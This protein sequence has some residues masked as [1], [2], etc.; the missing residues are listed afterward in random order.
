MNPLRE[1][2]GNRR[3]VLAHDWLTGMRGG[4]RVLER[5]C[6][7]FPEAPLATLIADPAAVTPAIRNR[8]IITSTLQHIP[9][10]Q[11]HYRHF[12][13]LFPLAASS[14]RLPPADLVISTSHCVAKSFRAPPGARH[15]CYCFTPMRYAW[16][17]HD[18]YLG[19]TGIKRHAARPALAALRRWDYRTRNRVDHYIAISR[20]IRERI[21]RCYGCDSDV[22]YPPVN[23]SR[24]MPGDLPPDAGQYD[25][26]VSALVPYKR[27]DL[28]VRAYART[29]FPLRIV[30][31][32]T[33][34]ESLQA[35]A[36]PNV[37]FLGWRDDAELTALYRGCR[38]LIFP[39][40]E[41]FGI[42]PLEAQACGRPVVAFARGGACETVLDG[43]TGLFFH[44][45]TETALAAAVEQ[46]SGHAWQ[47][48]RIRQHAEA[49][50]EDR[51]DN[52]LADAVTSR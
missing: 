44:E 49:F 33:V 31:T 15:V 9:G 34:A 45:Q 50:G 17:F 32:G 28:A 46:A 16:L 25:L 11:K 40:E 2:V 26:L 22:V 1:R 41:D 6:R 29:G 5:L 21:R 35:E 14:L 13:P 48:N 19:R 18:E 10:I 36:P 37:T 23:T 30:G 39:G 43:E 24:C 12:L 47:P 4:E 51:F 38:L 20:H 27:V 7:A 42:V 52:E 3:V 8:P